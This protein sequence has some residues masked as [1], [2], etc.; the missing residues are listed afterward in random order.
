[1]NHSLEHQTSLNTV[2]FFGSLKRSADIRMRQCSDHVHSPFSGETCFDNLKE[3][4]NALRA[5]LLPVEVRTTWICTHKL[6]K[7]LKGC[8]TCII[9][10]NPYI[11]KPCT[12]RTYFTYNLLAHFS[13]VYIHFVVHNDKSLGLKQAVCLCKLWKWHYNQYITSSYLTITCALTSGE[14]KGEWLCYVMGHLSDS[15]M[16]GAHVYNAMTSL[17]CVTVLSE[18]VCPSPSVCGLQHI[19]GAPL[20]ASDS[21]CQS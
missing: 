20:G 19:H 6:S 4:E 7:L 15:I 10:I 14:C 8:T 9:I 2:Y 1:M 13:D 12:M 18:C 5:G 3:H 21:L 16:N 17:C 11:L